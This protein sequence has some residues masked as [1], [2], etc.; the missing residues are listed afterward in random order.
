MCL[1]E[2]RQHWLGRPRTSR[3]RWQPVQRPR[4]RRLNVEA[5][6]NRRLLSVSPSPT[7]VANISPFDPLGAPQGGVVEDSHGNLFGVASNTNSL[8]ELAAGSHSPTT[9]ASFGGASGSLPQGIAIDGQNNIFGTTSE[10][11][12]YNDGTAFK[13]GAGSGGAITPL[14]PFNGESPQGTPFV[15]GNGNLYGVANSVGG[16]STIVYEVAND[17]NTV[18][19]LA[20]FNTALDGSPNPSVVADANGNVFGTTGNGGEYSD[21][22]VFEVVAGNG[23]VSTLVSFNTSSCPTG[24]GPVGGLIADSSGNLYGATTEGGQYGKGTVFEMPENGGAISILANNLEIPT[25]I[26]T[27]DSSGD[28][29]GSANYGVDNPPNNYYPVGASQEVSSVFEVAAGSGT[30]TQVAGFW[31]IVPYPFDGGGGLAAPSSLFVDSHG[32]LL[33]AAQNVAY[34][35]PAGY[36]TVFEIPAITAGALTPPS[37]TAGQAFNNATVLQF[38]G[39][40]SNSADYTAVVTLGDGNSVTLNSNGVVNGPGITNAPG[41]SGQIVPDPNGGFDV[42]L[43][44]TYAEALSNQAFEVVVSNTGGASTSASTSTFSV[45]IN[46]TATSLQALPTIPINGQPLTL[47][48]TVGVN[49]PGSGTPD[50]CVTF[51]DASGPLGTAPS[52]PIATTP[53]PRLPCP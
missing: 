26:L 31:D 52:S 45:A 8:Y 37:V 32:D 1:N 25:T 22:S 24:G 17:S 30:Y 7:I 33:G 51:S 53:M 49:Y 34:G 10:G 40:D 6:E 4:E 28:L 2:L 50:G 47:T 27:R 19:T 41:A 16:G 42:Q 5:L 9:F 18:T 21:G 12:L 23:T 48:A 38:S 14:A 3:R 36:G 43:S 15:D 44:Y 46:P 20:T 35:Y 39:L 11:G 29:F 13:I